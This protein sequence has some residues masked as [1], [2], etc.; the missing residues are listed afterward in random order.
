MWLFLNYWNIVDSELMLN[1][2]MTTT[3]LSSN[4]ANQLKSALYTVCWIIQES[5]FAIV[6]SVSLKVWWLSKYKLDG[7]IVLYWNKKE[8]IVT[9][10]RRG[11]FLIYV[12]TRIVET[13]RFG[14]DV[15]NL[16]ISRNVTPERTRSQIKW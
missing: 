13:K 7:K 2:I 3:Y 5:K 16:P 6:S 4:K 1:S 11:I 15:G 9:I 12:R 14:E 8:S 10:L